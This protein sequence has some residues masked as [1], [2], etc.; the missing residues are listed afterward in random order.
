MI[1]ALTQNVVMVRQKRPA[2]NLD[3][4]Y[5]RSNMATAQRTAQ[6]DQNQLLISD[7]LGS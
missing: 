2:L 7:L 5:S 6:V 1:L 4:L 3:F